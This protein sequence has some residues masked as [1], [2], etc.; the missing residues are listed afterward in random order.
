VTMREAVKYLPQ[1]DQ[2]R[3]MA[4]YRRHEPAPA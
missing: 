2:E 4:A 3:L 1:S